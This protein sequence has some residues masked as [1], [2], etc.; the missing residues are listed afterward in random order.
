LGLGHIQV[1]NTCIQVSD[2]L[3]MD[4]METSVIDSRATITHD[5]PSPMIIS[6]NGPA[7]TI[8]VEATVISA[9]P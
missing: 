7:S 5:H 8:V 1:D 4:V 6:F 2:I 9:P 3:L